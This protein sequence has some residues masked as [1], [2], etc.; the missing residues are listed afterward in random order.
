GLP[1]LTDFVRCRDAVHGAVQLNI[2][3]DEVRTTLFGEAESFLSCARS[4]HYVVT[5]L[6]QL[7]SHIHRENLLV[8]DDQNLFSIPVFIHSS[9]SD[10]AEGNSTRAIVPA[11]DRSSSVPR[12]CRTIPCTSIRPSD[13]A[14]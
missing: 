9:N 4:A 12:S 5:E 8:F 11:S 2:H 3:E 14:C 10:P 1:P 13:E 6:G 7:S